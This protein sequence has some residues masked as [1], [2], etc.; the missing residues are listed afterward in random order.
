MHSQFAILN[1]G[2]KTTTRTITIGRQVSAQVTIVNMC[3]MGRMP[4][5][6]PHYFMAFRS[7]SYKSK[8]DPSIYA[9]YVINNIKKNLEIRRLCAVYI[10]SGFR[11]L[12]ILIILILII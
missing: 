9:V 11:K 5:F 7:D 6:C 8:N 4:T 1:N 10:F 12:E 2:N 3:T